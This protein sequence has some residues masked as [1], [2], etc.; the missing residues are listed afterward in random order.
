[1]QRTMASAAAGLFFLSL[2]TGGLLAAAM[3]GSVSADARSVLAAHLGGLMGCFLLLGVAWT[4][5]LLCYAEA[6]RRRLCWAFV[7]GCY[8]NWAVTLLKARLRVSGLAWT[9]D[10]AN[11]LVFVL[12]MLLVVLPFL[13]AG[14][15]WIAGLGGKARG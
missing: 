14:A 11:D 10:G 4:L 1:M 7:V 9:G 12:L 5:P 2:L 8:A 3:T 13:G 15:A 6:G